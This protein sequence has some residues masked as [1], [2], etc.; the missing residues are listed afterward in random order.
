MGLL[1]AY[2]LDPVLDV[3][4]EPIGLDKFI[5]GLLV[6]PAGLDQRAQHRL[7]RALA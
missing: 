5:G 7:R 2:H 4:Q 3:A 1:V 6:D